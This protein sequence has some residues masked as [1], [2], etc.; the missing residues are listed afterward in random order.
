[1]HLG[2]NISR[3]RSYRGMKQDDMAKR[4]KMTQQNYSLI[5]NAEHISD[6][7]LK[8]VAAALDYDVDFIK[9][10]PDAPYVYSNNQQ[11]G[12]VVNYEFN[13]MEKIIQLYEGLLATERKKV[14]ELESQ[15]KAKG[16]K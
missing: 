16:K 2:R 5:E 3:L 1:M 14:S 10:M 4:L 9:Q 12:N 13:P 7:V 11:G 15:L 8:K 6:A